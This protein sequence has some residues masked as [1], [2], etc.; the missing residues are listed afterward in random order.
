MTPL[1]QGSR[2]GLAATFAYAFAGLRYAVRTQST[3]RLLLIIAVA[4]AALTVALGL[5]TTRTAI[6]M[7]A[8]ALVIAAEL[9]NTGVE[10]VVD[11]LVEQNHHSAAKVAKDIAAG[12]V[13]TTAVAAA[14]VGVLVLGPP[15]GEALGLAR[16]LAVSISR[17]AAAVLL[18]AGAVGF[19]RLL[20]GNGNRE[21]GNGRTFS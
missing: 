5:S 16:G 21:T 2:R 14:V 11:L 4:V 9:F 6:V 3:F 10:A 15:L 7:L 17:W 20:F 1:S 19:I 8:M 18:A 12:S 13:L